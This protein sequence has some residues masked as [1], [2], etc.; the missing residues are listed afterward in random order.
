MAWPTGTRNE[1]INSDFS[2]WIAGAAPAAPLR[3]PAALQ[4]NAAGASTVG[5]RLCYIDV[6]DGGFGAEPRSIVQID[7]E[8]VTQHLTKKIRL[9]GF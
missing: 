7:Q 6:L 8:L 3:E 4:S 2:F 1:R 9:F 5:K